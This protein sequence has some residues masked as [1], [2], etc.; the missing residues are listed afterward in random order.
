MDLVA[1][2]E[3][4]GKP[5]FGVCRGL[6]LLNVAYGGTLYQDIQTPR[7]GALQHR[8]AVTYDGNFPTVD[9]QPG[10]ALARLYP[11]ATRVKV[12]SIHHQAIKDLAAGFAVEA[13]SN[14]DG[15]IESIRRRDAA[16][17]Y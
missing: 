2:F 10:S 4:A 13:V 17:P 7:P 16:K 6:Q 5:V 15:L 1:A 9:L 14:E 12:N 3:R 11:G 8:D